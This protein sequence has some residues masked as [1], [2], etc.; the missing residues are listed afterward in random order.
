MN[1]AV[2]GITALIPLLCVIAA[3]TATAEAGALEHVTVRAQARQPWGESSGLLSGPLDP[4]DAPTPAITVADLAR[5][6][7]SIAHAGQGGLLQTLSIRGLSGQQVA[8]FWG[9]LPILS[10][11]RA[12][13]A[14]SFIDPTMLGELSV[15]RGPASAYYGN[16]GGAGV[17]QLSPRRP[18][19]LEWQLQWGSEGDENL[20]Y[21]GAGGRDWSLA[22]SRRSANESDT[23]DGERLHTRFD[24]YN[25]QATVDF[26]LGEKTLSLQHLIS[27]GR[28]IG[29][30]NNRFPDQVTDYPEERH[31]LGQASLAGDE[32]LSASVFYHYQELDT[33]VEQAGASLNEV[34]SESLDFGGRVAFDWPDS[35]LN[36]RTG[37]EYLGRRD[38]QSDEKET[39]L[40][41]AA[42]THQQ[43]LDAEQDGIDLFA[44]A[45]RRLGPL[46]LS[47][48]VRW[49]W[50]EQENRDT[51]S[52]DD[53]AWSGFARADW[54]LGA[55]STSL[56]IASGTRFA[57]VSERFFSGTTG[58][59]QVLGNPEL[60]P[61]ET[62]GVDLGL[63][64]QGS[65][66]TVEAH[67]YSL[68][69]DDYIE[70]VDLDNDTRS[71]QNLTEGEINGA[72]I[73]ARLNIAE[74]WQLDLGGHY[75]DAEDDDGTPL[76]DIPAPTAYAALRYAGAAWR[77]DLR[78][79][80]RFSE[81]DVAPGEQSLDEAALLQFSVE[82]DFARGLRLRVWSRNLLD[83]SY[84][85]ASDNRA[86]EGPE[87][88]V[89]LTLSWREPAS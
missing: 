4:T 9:D 31:W 43:T 68:H 77:S 75:L 81:N 27:E 87:R 1:I 5:L 10:D 7:P 20:Q 30:S 48:G 24:Q 32:G 52:E 80:Y 13:T 6:Q 74:A 26:E 54:V 34:S 57:G 40:I 60:D 50:L 84:R 19:G 56:E 76:S 53:T 3:P 86:T 35:P 11:R 55:W 14:S 65:L 18:T 61:E 46:D 29:K 72:E 44:D 69:I 88:S 51:D 85:L 59:G 2:P 39:S 36:L 73:A 45:R 28:D 23:P 21:L 37:V 89:G 47:A 78:L 42:G 17:L 83:E 58:R 38:V 12:G 41:T 66:G 15:L 16:G 63:Q 62:L 8:N 67:I 70:R 79:D 64:W 25:I 33:R 71:F 82:R 22:F 49:A